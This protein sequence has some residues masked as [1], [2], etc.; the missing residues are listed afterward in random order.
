LRHGLITAPEAV[1]SEVLDRLK[2]ILG[3]YFDHRGPAG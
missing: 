3:K 2:P 1:S